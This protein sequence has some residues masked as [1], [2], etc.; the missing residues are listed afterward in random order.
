[1]RVN[2]GQGDGDGVHL[3]TRAVPRGRGADRRSLQASL[4]LPSPRMSLLP[5]AWLALSLALHPTGNTHRSRFLS[6][7]RPVPSHASS[8]S[9]A[10][11]PGDRR[12]RAVAAEVG[13]PVLRGP[14]F[15]SG[16]RRAVFAYPGG[17]ENTPELKRRLRAGPFR[18][19]RTE[20][21]SRVDNGSSEEDRLRLPETP[22]PARTC[23]QDSPLSLEVGT[24]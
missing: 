18:E 22:P 17:T 20:R 3:G 14:A 10:Q 8:A 13:E 1:M 6:W 21:L 12:R 11:D 7:S 9:P 15:R 23:G 19:A 5:R 4:Q 24:H 16:S 2:G